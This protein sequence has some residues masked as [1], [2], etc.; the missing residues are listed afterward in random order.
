M[1]VQDDMFD[2]ALL[3]YRHYSATL[4]KFLPECEGKVR[5]PWANNDFSFRF[6]GQVPVSAYEDLIDGWPYAD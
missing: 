4:G 5:P 6:T 2:N 3:P 1:E